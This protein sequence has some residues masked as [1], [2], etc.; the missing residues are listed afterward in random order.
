MNLGSNGGHNKNNLCSKAFRG[1]GKDN[2]D[3]VDV[4][5]TRNYACDFQTSET[6][7]IELLFN[8]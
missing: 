5:V 1:N 3:V 4:K 6:N 7:N 8:T 2:K